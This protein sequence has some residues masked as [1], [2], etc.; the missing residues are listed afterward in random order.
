M[1]MEQ[2]F[3]FN[4]ERSSMLQKQE[5]EIFHE[6][7]ERPKVQYFTSMLLR[8]D[9]NASQV[10]KEG[11]RYFSHQQNLRNIENKNDVITAIEADR[12]IL[13]YAFSDN[14]H[15]FGGESWQ[16]NDTKDIELVNVI[17]DEEFKKYTLFDFGDAFEPK[18]SSPN[19]LL[20][21]ESRKKFMDEVAGYMQFHGLGDK[22]GKDTKLATALLSKVDALC[23]GN[24]SDGELFKAALKKSELDLTSSDMQ[25][26]F[27][28]L[29]E[30]SAEAEYRVVVM[31]ND[32][33]TRLSLLRKSAIK[34]L[35]EKQKGNLSKAA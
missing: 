31:F 18:K 10:I 23:S 26:Y 33:I 13:K 12:V 32:I 15:G 2:K 21:E 35:A 8:G 7:D 22:N 11:D 19:V 20:G 6:I 16:D 25:E 5:G 30:G 24:L 3:G 34:Y 29:G 27:E 17:T 14:D 1:N 9:M 4:P 28:F